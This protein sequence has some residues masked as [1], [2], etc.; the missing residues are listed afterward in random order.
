VSRLARWCYIMQSTE[1]HYYVETLD[2]DR[3][4][5]VCEQHEKRPK[6]TG[7][8][9]SYLQSKFNRPC[10]GWGKACEVAEWNKKHPKHQIR[11]YQQR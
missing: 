4:A 5:F 7:K 9:D 1:T 2:D 3:Y 6:P 8:V 10:Y 11:I